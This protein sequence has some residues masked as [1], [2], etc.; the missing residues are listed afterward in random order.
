M[1]QDP[2]QVLGLSPNASDDEVKKAYR[3]LAKKYH[4]DLNPGD[5]NAEAKMKEIN[6]AYNQ[7]MNR[8]KNGGSA[9]GYGNASGYGSQGSYGSYGSQGQGGYRDFED[10]FGGFG[11]GGF[12]GSGNY[13]SSTRSSNPKMQAA[14]NYINAGHYSEALHV[15]DEILSYE[16]DQI[17]TVE[18]HDVAALEIDPEA[19]I[20]VGQINEVKGRGYTLNRVHKTLTKPQPTEDGM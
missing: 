1:I 13:G 14:R 20:I 19:F 15:L 8:Q 2:Y 11:F 16:V 3:Q 18:P 10:F 5:K 4:P 9:G 7:I 6:A 17:L 12:G